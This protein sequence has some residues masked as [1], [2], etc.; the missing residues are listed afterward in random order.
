MNKKTRKFHFRTGYFAIFVGIICLFFMFEG[1]FCKNGEY[2]FDFVSA[3]GTF[4]Y[5]DLKILFIPAYWFLM[6]FGFGISVINSFKKRK[7]YNFNIAEAII[8]PTVFL[9]TSF[10]GAKLLF[11]LER[12]VSAPGEGIDFSGMSLF[13]AIYLVPIVICIVCLFTKRYK[14]NTLLDYCAPFVLII[15]S[16][17]RFGCFISG[18]CGAKTLWINDNPV[19]VPIQLIE[20]IF[21]IVILDYCLIIEKSAIE[22][23]GKAGTGL[24]YPIMLIGY[25]GCRFFIEFVRN[26]PKELIIFSNGQLFAVI[27][28]IIGFIMLKN[29]QKRSKEQKLETKQQTDNEKA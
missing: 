19:I 3:G 26:S 12:L 14:I 23:N 28:I 22:E 18:C 29:I 1:I 24:I 25:G 21:D 27:A 13:G 15:L 17:I 16:F 10:L 5:N 8:I 9:V 6:F 4:A 20:V 11:A 7:L 2:H